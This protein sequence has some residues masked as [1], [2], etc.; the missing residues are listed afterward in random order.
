ML[1]MSKDI[2]FLS[3]ATAVLLATGLG[4]L[5]PAPHWIMLGAE[6]GLLNSITDIGLSPVA[7]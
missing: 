2:F 7:E 5:L 4:C 6:D 1:E 3:V